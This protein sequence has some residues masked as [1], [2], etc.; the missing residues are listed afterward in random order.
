MAEVFVCK[1]IYVDTSESTPV[2]RIVPYAVLMGDVK[3]IFSHQN[4]GTVFANRCKKCAFLMAN[5]D[6]LWFIIPFSKAVRLWQA[7]EGDTVQ[8]KEVTSDVSPN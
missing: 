3:R 4:V 6:V 8:A 1:R 2:E 5:G 7:Y